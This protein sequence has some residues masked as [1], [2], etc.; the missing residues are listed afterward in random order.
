MFD[1]VISEGAVEDLTEAEVLDAAGACARLARA[2]EARLLVMA[3]QWAVLHHPDRLTAARSAGGSG[4]VGREG[5]RQYGGAGTDPVREFA[6]AE[7]GAR[8]GVSTY[9]A[10]RLIADAQDLHDRLPLLYARVLAG[11]VRVSYARF[12]AERTRELSKEE[13]GE[14]DAEVVE[15]AD[16]RLPWSRFADLVEGRVV[17]AAPER[18]RARE[19]RKRTA[20]FARVV[21]TAEAGMA[22]FMIRADIATIDLIDGTVATVADRLA[23]RMPDDPHPE[24]AAAEGAVP[25]SVDD[26]R[27]QAMRLL[28]RPD[29]DDDADLAD[30][31][32]GVRLVVH[33][34]H[35]PAGP[36]ADGAGEPVDRVARVEGHGPVTGH[37]LCSVLGPQARFTVQPV[38]HPLAQAPADAYEIPARL[39]TAVKILSPAD[40]FPW[41]TCTSD[42]M[43]LDHTVPYGAP[44][45]PA[46]DDPGGGGPTAIGNLAPL[47]RTHHRIKTFGRWQHRQPFPGIHLWRDAFGQ[48]YLVDYTG[49]RSLSCSDDVSG[50]CSTGGAVGAGG[51]GGARGAGGAGGPVAPGGSR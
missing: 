51:A 30:L 10:V 47:T 35:D 42:G 29:A 24:E 12:V 8:I 44:P 33:L 32:P 1:Y 31:L 17:A 22:T 48:V 21:G 39:R 23:E 19:E 28:C 45:G 4:K 38:F 50:D 37:W 14:V 34:L 2:A 3:Y 9:T 43:D 6:A 18:A 5:P 27:V 16:G 13:A 36:D 7:L 46:P 40:C 26:R 11:E 20:R 25:V 49:T 41:G 15:S